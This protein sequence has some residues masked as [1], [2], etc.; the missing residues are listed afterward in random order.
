MKICPDVTLSFPR[1]DGKT[2]NIK[3]GEDASFETSYDKTSQ[4][5]YFIFL[6]EETQ[7]CHP[8]FC[9]CYKSKRAVRSILRCEVIAFVDGFDMAY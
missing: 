8:M 1:L 3:F 9:S 7:K 4:L 5:G 2:L 6:V